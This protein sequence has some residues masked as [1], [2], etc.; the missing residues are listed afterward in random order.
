VAVDVHHH[1]RRERG[2]RGEWDR[3]RERRA[4]HPG[5]GSDVPH[6]G[7]VLTP[8]LTSGASIQLDGDVHAQ[9]L[10]RVE[11]GVDLIEMNHGAKEQPCTDQEHE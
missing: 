11:A 6:H 7:E 4:F 1:L 5:E 10:S 2:G 3:A 9:D 8:D